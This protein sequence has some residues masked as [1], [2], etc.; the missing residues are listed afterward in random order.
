MK[1]YNYIMRLPALALIAM[2]LC[3]GTFLS[4]C[5]DEEVI[6]DDVV[7]ESFGPSG[8]KHGES[9]KFIG[10]NLDRVTAIVLPNAEVAKSE[11][12]TQTN[13]LIELVVPKA[14]QAGKVILKTPDG[15]ITSKA[16]LSF[17]VP[18]VIESITAEAKP[19]TDITITGDMVNWIEEV[20]FAE[21]ISV[22]E[23]VSSSLN[24]LV[25]TVPMEAQTGQ[26]IFSSGGTEP[27]SFV[28]EEE[29]I[30][31][32]PKV[33]ELNPAAIRHTENLTIKGTDLDLVTSVILEGDTVTEFVSQSA[34]EIVLTVSPKV[35][36][37]TLTLIQ[38]SPVEVVTSQELTIIL[39]VGTAL[40][41]QPAVPGVDD[42]T[43]TGINL[44]LVAQLT[45]PGIE[46][47]VLAADFKSHSAE[48]IVLALPADVKAGG[49]RYTTIHGY[50]NLLGV[51]VV[52][53]GPGPKPLAIT[54]YDGEFHLD[55][56]P[57]SWNG[58][59]DPESTE[60][61]YTGTMSYKFTT[62]GDGGAKIVGTSVDASQMGV[63][64]F[65]LFGGPGTDGKNVA[66]ILGSGG[67]DNWGNYN[68]V[69][70]VE[71]EWT[72]YRLDLSR[73][74]GVDLSAVT[75]FVFK[76]EGPDAAGDVIY[77]D[78]VGFDP[79]GPAPAPELQKVL[80]DD[81]AKNGLG[82]WG[83]FGGT[84]TDFDNAEPVRE[85][86]KS[87]KATYV[88]GWGGAPQF[89]G[90]DGFQIDGHANFA[91]SIFGGA[92]TGGKEV[93][94]LIKTDTGEHEAFIEVVEG[95]WKDVAIPFADLGSPQVI[96][97]LFFQDADFAGD[98]YFDYIGVR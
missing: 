67:N 34:N 10:R 71:G 64:V 68:A 65:S 18:V 36:K 84:T 56:R 19:G 86:A 5:D 97:E 85:G 37:G 6:S 1:I 13:S 73:Y 33:T 38:L 89:G 98:V 40:A 82:A 93:K 88:G 57:E 16:M 44:D 83:G 27:L 61:A 63:Y 70:L 58:T 41:P 94:L 72:E 9:I 77:I 96:N 7:L 8:V 2:L 62:D 39:P 15:D 11:F 50:A 20:V 4:S 31:T 47:P 66:V 45:L 14:A 92:G 43:I 28:S 78:R 69:P 91:F 21:G 55:G 30:V 35:E 74:S 54:V 3:A 79:A 52:L 26:L 95:E 60:Q 25:V 90:G 29:L 46:E 51:N 42:I 17:E 59:R 76:P 87:I 49:V 48:E 23:F 32:L 24:E 75:N 53:P 12:T 80:Y 22:T 81:A